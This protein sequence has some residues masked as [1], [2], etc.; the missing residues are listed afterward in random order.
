MIDY[1]AAA[2]L[3]EETAQSDEREELSWLEWVT[4][5]VDAALAGGVVVSLDGASV[6]DEVPDGEIELTIYMDRETGVD[7]FRRK[8]RVLIVPLEEET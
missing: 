3:A 8:V 7:W 4:M 1:E 2:R 5:V 6:G